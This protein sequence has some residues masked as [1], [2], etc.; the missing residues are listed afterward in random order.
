[1]IT[2]FDVP[3]AF[4]QSIFDVCIF[5]LRLGVSLVIF[6]AGG[7]ASSAGDA[8]SLGCTVYED[9]S[10]T[11]V[12]HRD[13]YRDDL[14]SGETGEMRRARDANIDVF[15]PSSVNVWLVTRMPWLQ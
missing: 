4:G 6:V 12:H 9:M 14:I 5:L 7:T 13:F 11:I 1:L 15:V 8:A 3:L 2:D 10:S